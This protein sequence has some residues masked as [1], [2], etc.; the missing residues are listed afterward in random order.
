MADLSRDLLNLVRGTGTLCLD[1]DDPG[2]DNARGYL[3]DESTATLYFPVSK[4][5]LPERGNHFQ[6]LIWSQP[7]VVATGDLFPATSDV[8]LD[9]QLSLAER[10][11][12]PDEARYMLLD[13]RTKRPR[14]SRYKLVI[15]ELSATGLETAEG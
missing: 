13:Q 4:R 11:L 15:R 3:F 9:V 8:D 10:R 1:V 2:W 14:R 12:A 5:Y 7:R 6:V